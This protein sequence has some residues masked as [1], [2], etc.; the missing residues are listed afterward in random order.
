MVGITVV[1]PVPITP[2]QLIYK[3]SPACICAFGSDPNSVIDGGDYEC[4]VKSSVNEISPKTNVV[5]EGAPGAPGGVQVNG[6]DGANNGPPIRYYNILGRTNWNRTWVNVSTH[7]QAHEIDRYTSRQQAA[8]SNL[9]PCSSYEFSVAAVKELGTDGGGGKIGDLTITW[10]PLLPQEQ[11][12]HGIYYKVFWRL[13]GKLEWGSEIIKR[14]DN[15][16]MANIPLNNYYTEYEVKVQALN[17]VGKGP[18]SEVVVMYSAEN[19]PLVAPQ[20]PKPHAFNSTAFNVTWG[21]IVGLQPDTYYFVK[22]MACNAAG[23]GPKSERAE[24]RTYRKAP[25]KPPSSVHIYGIN[26]STVR[27]VRRYVSPAQDEEPTKGCKGIDICYM[28]K[29]LD[30]DALVFCIDSTYVYLGSKFCEFEKEHHYS[31]YN[32]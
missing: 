11:H 26:P 32:S 24:E 28:L 14:Q 5:V 17:N 21:L 3:S 13:K 22:V 7:V 6:M 31:P 10:D 9:T 30:M 18:E 15:I 19:M 20:K 27:V 1:A 8:I 16:G 23:E 29:A 2:W 25:Q 12:S 4:V